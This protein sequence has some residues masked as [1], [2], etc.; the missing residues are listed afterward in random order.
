MSIIQK[1]LK[2]VE[3]EKIKKLEVKIHREALKWDKYLFDNLLS[4]SFFVA[5]DED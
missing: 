2:R 4:H 5:F 3:S 1:F